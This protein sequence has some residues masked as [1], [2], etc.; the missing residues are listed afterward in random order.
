MHFLSSV[1]IRLDNASSR[2]SVPRP[3]AILSSKKV[4]NAAPGLKKAAVGG[5]LGWGPPT[6]LLQ[7]VLDLIVRACL[8]CRSC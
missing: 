6:V 5:G 2:M 3:C 8:L 1:A 7:L 4:R